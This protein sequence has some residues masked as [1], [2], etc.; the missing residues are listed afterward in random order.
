MAPRPLFR[1]LGRRARGAWIGVC[2]GLASAGTAL[3]C[4][5]APHLATQMPESVSTTWADGRVAWYDA[6]T[7][8]Y[9]HGVLG[10]AVEGGRLHAYS[11]DAVTPCGEQ[12][13][14]LPE[15]L[16][17]EDTA[18]RLLDLDGDGQPEIVVVQ[19]HRRLGAQLAVYG[20]SSDGIGLSLIAATPFIGRWT[21]MAMDLSRSPMSIVRIWRGLCGC[22]GLWMAR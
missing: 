2:L 17:F 1:A 21:W 15:E 14:T 6:P 16:V 22:G 5:V 12:S 20:F 10:D 13:I 9:A 18:P 7:T 19:S 11:S 3:G 4:T 8:R